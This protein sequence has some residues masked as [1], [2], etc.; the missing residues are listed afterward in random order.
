MSDKKEN[1]RLSSGGDSGAIVVE[2]IISLTSFVFAIVTVLTVVNI[3]L[4]QARMAHAIN[5]TASEIS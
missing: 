3:C 1:V 4:I 2:A 5:T